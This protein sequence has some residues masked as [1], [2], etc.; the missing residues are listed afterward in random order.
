MAINNI[1]GFTYPLD[2]DRQGGLS[3]SIGP[4]RIFQQIIE[5]LDTA[6]GERVYR[7]RFGGPSLAFRSIQAVELI[8]IE[9]QSLLESVLPSQ[10]VSNVQV[11]VAST[12]LIEGQ[13]ELQVR[14]IYIPSRTRQTLLYSNVNTQRP[15]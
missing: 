14:Y 6:I 2:V 3:L 5:T 4:N 1:I 11:E 13:V 12:N 7:P 8:V 15:Q 9:L 10:Y